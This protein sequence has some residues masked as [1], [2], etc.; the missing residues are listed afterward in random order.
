MAPLRHRTPIA[1]G[2]RAWA[3]CV[4]VLQCE[5]GGRPVTAVY[6]FWALLYSAF[7]AQDLSDEAATTSL[8][9]AL[10]AAFALAVR[11]IATM[12]MGEGRAAAAEVALHCLGC[13]GVAFAAWALVH[14]AA[15][16][17]DAHGHGR[18]ALALCAGAAPALLA[19]R[20]GAHLPVPS[21]AVRGSLPLA[22]HSRVNARAGVGVA[23]GS[24]RRANMG[25]RARRHARELRCRGGRAAAACSRPAAAAAAAPETTATHRRAGV[26]RGRRRGRGGP[27]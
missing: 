16:P 27:A 18:L 19:A 25:A 15:A 13:A 14:D 7:G 12:S 24:R 5:R 23:R 17:A 8:L 4:I 6:G 3:A 21:V 11:V 20:S 26:L 1:P 10:A 2:Y 9:G 22:T